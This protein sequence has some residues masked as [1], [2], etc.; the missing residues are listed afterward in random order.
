[1]N[2]S[3]N[4]GNEFNIDTQFTGVEVKPQEA[5][6]PKKP[7]LGRG[8]K[9]ALLSTLG[10]IGLVLVFSTFVFISAGSGSESSVLGI[11]NQWLNFVL[12]GLGIMFVVVGLLSLIVFLSST[13]KFMT[14][15]NE[16]NSRKKI[17]F[18]RLVVSLIGLI[19]S[20]VLAVVLLNFSGNDFGGNEEISGIITNPVDTIGLSAPIKIDFD[21]TKVPFDNTLYRVVSYQWSFGDGETATG[22][23]VEH[24]F[25]RKP[26]SGFY[27]TVLTLNLENAEG[28]IVK[29]P[30]KKTIGIENEKIVPV[31]DVSV[32]KGRAPLKVSFDA[33]RS[34]DPDGKIVSYEWDFNNDGIAEETGQTAEFEFNEMGEFDVTLFL[35]DSN[36]ETVTGSKVISVL[37]QD[38]IMGVI[39]NSPEDEILSPERSYTFDASESVSD[40]GIIENFE[41]DFGD[42]VIR[43]GKQVSYA[44]ENE[45]IYTVKLRM[46]DDKGN[47]TNVTKEYIVSNSPS[48]L[49]ANIQTTP[50]KNENAEALV[51]TTPF[52]V[53]FTGGHSS[54]TNEEIVEYKWDFDNDGTVDA[55]GQNVEYVFTESGSFTTNLSII[56]ATGKSAVK[57]IQVEV[58]GSALKPIVTAEPN[59]GQVPL[60]VK[61]DATATKEPADSN[62]V[63]FRWD[64]GDGTP[65]KKGLPIMTHRYDRTGDFKVTVTAITDTNEIASSEVLVFVNPVPLQACFEQSRETGS[66]PLTISFD[67]KCSTGPASKF[68]WSFGNGDTSI[69]R[70]PTYTFTESGTYEVELEV[71]SVDNDVST[72]RNTI[73][74]E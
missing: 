5:T 6:K 51:G 70:K 49:F 29:L 64:F 17:Y 66:A 47:E 37:N 15:K 7:S 19:I 8:A 73:V 38:I 11:G 62:I 46:N 1:M 74:V 63:S 9:I 34:V 67:P 35:T 21:A 54:A 60:T 45:G 2:N 25:L 43:Q 10:L 55:S 18:K 33:S 68:N 26:D 41:W 12:L 14:V 22:P 32:E 65:I 4:V 69:D 42:G 36:G 20:S 16:E 23:M 71:V 40:E 24:E 13:F 59:V 30:V 61:F 56:S 44:F 53:N 58:A 31:I 72:F 3:F 52:R 57:Q 48:G 50:E 28:E 39:T 27:E